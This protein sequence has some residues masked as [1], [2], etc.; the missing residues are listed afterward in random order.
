MLLVAGCRTVPQPE[1]PVPAEPELRFEAVT[2]ESLPGWQQDRTVEAWPALLASC[3]TSRMAAAW[4]AFAVVEMAA[5]AL[6]RAE[7]QAGAVVRVDAI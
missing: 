7:D 4:R 1:P 6:D 3:G 5:G 2:W